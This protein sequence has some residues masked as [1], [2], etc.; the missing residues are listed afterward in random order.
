MTA[1]DGPIASCQSASVAKV[2]EWEGNLESFE[3]QKF[4]SSNFLLS[5]PCRQQAVLIGDAD[6][7]LTRWR[8]DVKQIQ[9]KQ[10]AQG[11]DDLPRQCHSAVR[12]MIIGVH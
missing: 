2:K 1:S 11:F 4:S 7:R 12:F 9:L 6:H 8:C 3:G 5:R 10:E